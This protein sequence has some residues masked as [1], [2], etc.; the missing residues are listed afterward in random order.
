[1]CNDLEECDQNIS[2]KIIRRHNFPLSRCHNIIIFYKETNLQSNKTESYTAEH[3]K[4]DFWM[5][6][7]I[8][9]SRVNCTFSNIYIYRPYHLSDVSKSTPCYVPSIVPYLQLQSQMQ[10]CDT[11]CLSWG[12]Q[13]FFECFLCAEKFPLKSSRGKLFTS[14]YSNG[15]PG[16][17]AAQVKTWNVLRV[18][19]YS[20]GQWDIGQKSHVAQKTC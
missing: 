20:A 4:L 5:V 16:N 6:A 3:I 1:M 2:C 17:F 15:Y 9:K 11:F 8:V 12:G 13:Y 10:V 14:R 7:R 19:L 18:R